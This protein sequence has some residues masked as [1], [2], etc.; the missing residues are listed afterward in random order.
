MDNAAAFRRYSDGIYSVVCNVK[1]VSFF[2][3]LKR[4]TGL[5]THTR[6]SRGLFAFLFGLWLPIT[7]RISRALAAWAVELTEVSDVTAP[8]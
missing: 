7:V 6:T 2:R 3:A 8:S 4:L 5:R 1:S